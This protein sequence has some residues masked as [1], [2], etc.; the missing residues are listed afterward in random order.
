[1]IIIIIIIINNNNN[2]N[3]ENKPITIFILFFYF[4]ACTKAALLTQY[5][6]PH[7]DLLQRSCGVCMCMFISGQTS[8]AHCMCVSWGGIVE[9]LLCRVT[10][11]TL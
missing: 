1:M 11:A 7:S 9:Y 5:S 8:T 2:N 6:K 10:C 3:T 4:V